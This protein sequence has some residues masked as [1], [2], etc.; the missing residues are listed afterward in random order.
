MNGQAIVSTVVDGN[1][2]V[3]GARK[4]GAGD[5]NGD[6]RMDLVVVRASGVDVRVYYGSSNLTFT[7]GP[8]ITVTSEVRDAWVVKWGESKVP[9]VVLHGAAGIGVYT[10]DLVS[11]SVLRTTPPGPAI[12]AAGVF[13]LPSGEQGIGWT[14]QL[15]AGSAQQKF[16]TYRQSGSTNWGQVG[17]AGGES[18]YEP[19]VAS[20]VMGDA[21][22]D[23][24]PDLV[25]GATGSGHLLYSRNLA[26]STGG[27]LSFDVGDTGLWPFIV[28]G[29]S[30]PNTAFR[31]TPVLADFNADRVTDLYVPVQNAP[32]QTTLLGPLDTQSAAF[33]G[34]PPAL[35]ITYAWSS[36]AIPP[37]S[38]DYPLPSQLKLRVADVW[39]NH[40]SATHLRV[41]VWRWPF[42]CSNSTA[43]NCTDPDRPLDTTARHNLYYH[44]TSGTLPDPFDIT[45]ALDS[46]EGNN[47]LAVY[48]IELSL[49]TATIGANTARVTNAWQTY[50]YGFA[51]QWSATAFA[52]GPIDRVEALPDADVTNEFDVDFYQPGSNAA[53][54]IGIIIPLPRQ[55][56]FAPNVVPVLG[57]PTEI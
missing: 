20:L 44:L 48:C 1:T 36:Y 22:S 43:A 15:S 19:G 13:T 35:P 50:S 34:T 18:P 26:R 30:S 25:L 45:L 31:A 9:R 10:P 49:V 29:A 51:R 12:D 32:G 41:I 46:A 28:T 54:D 8:E 39:T 47:D 40:A 24:Y 56:H 5:I 23:G 2:S 33:M 17:P 37:T 57:P 53:P 4:V 27:P 55:P 7:A 11:E 38:S 52:N 6:G 16:V 3:V 14:T 21:T 42:P